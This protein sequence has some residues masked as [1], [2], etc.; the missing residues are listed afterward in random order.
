MTET[1]LAPIAS[2]EQRSHLTAQ[3]Q[4]ELS[5]LLTERLRTYRSRVAQAA[6][7]LDGFTSSDSP[8]EREVARD[9]LQSMLAAMREHEDALTRLGT[10]TYGVCNLCARPI[11]FE[12]LE[13][14]PEVER[15][16]GCVRMG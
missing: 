10:G 9:T 1:A 11:P 5:T 4:R 7:A 16:V 2:R 13:A 14:I 15:C 3:Q 6:A 8:H 12:R